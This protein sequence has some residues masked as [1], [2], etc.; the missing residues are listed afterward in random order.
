[1]LAASS[2]EAA[3]R[4]AKAAMEQEDWQSAAA[5]LAGVDREAYK[6]RY[7]DLESLYLEAC[8]KAGID[9]YPE[10]EPEATQTPA[11]A[12]VTPGPEAE[13]TPEPTAN[14]FLVTEDEQ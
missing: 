13:P 9:P 11:P 6:R 8:E 1:M 4:K 7:R 14:P 10:T 12:D 3:Y 5:L 2:A